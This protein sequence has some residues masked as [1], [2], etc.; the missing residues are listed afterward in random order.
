[1]DR[2]DKGNSRKMLGLFKTLDQHSVST[3]TLRA[4]CCPG[5]SNF[6]ECQQLFNV[7]FS[8]D[9]ATQLGTYGGLPHHAWE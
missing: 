2:S 9:F 8:A 3:R 7:H 6:Y 4:G 1:M 5:I